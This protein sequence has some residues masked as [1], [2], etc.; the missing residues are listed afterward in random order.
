MATKKNRVEWDATDA[1]NEGAERTV[2]E[3]LLETERFNY[4]AEE[5]YQGAAALVLPG[6][7][8]RGGQST[9]GVGVGD[10]SRFF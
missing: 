4:H 5:K 9:R 6:E 7:R 2:W 8:F 10:A 3:T 1:R